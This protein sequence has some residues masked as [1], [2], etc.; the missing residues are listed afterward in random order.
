MKALSNLVT[1]L[2]LVLATQVLVAGGANRTGTGG[3]PELLI[4]VGARDI[5]MG[6]STVSTTSGIDA[7]FWNPAGITKSSS[8]SNL[9]FS[10]MSYIADIGVEY[11]AVTV[12]FADLGTI[13]LNVKSLSVGDIPVTTVDNPDGTG[14]VYNPQFF[15]GGLTYARQ[16]SDRISVGVTTQYISEHLAQANSSGFAFNAGVLYDNLG[17]INGLSLGV[18]VK[19]I[20]PQMSFGGAGLLIN[21]NATSQQS[22]PQY[23][24]N[25]SQPFELPSTIEFGVGY[26]V[27]L[28]G[29]NGLLIATTFENNNFSDDEYKVGGEYSYN[30]M[31]FVRAGYDFAP[32][33]E[34]AAYLY[35]F[36]AGA[37]VLVES[38]GT[39][40]GV[41]YAFRS[42]QYFSG[43]HII[44]LRLGF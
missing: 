29:E 12:N 25:P 1:L 19:N 36:T 21:A 27:P 43:N 7:L 34:K 30:K 31:F 5:G 23:Y 41:D 24:D 11:G 20:G 39:T 33:L 17:S 37:G 14:Q 38:E 18:A 6:G 35:G 40:V 42:T 8:S 13:G 16:L 26:Q 3:A 28:S 2:L 15:I 4:P 44:S 22:G 10:H 32:N 9:L